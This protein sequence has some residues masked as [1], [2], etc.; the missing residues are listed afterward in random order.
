MLEGPPPPSAG[1]PT[2]TPRVTTLAA[3]EDAQGVVAPVVEHGLL[4]AWVVQDHLPRAALILLL[5]MVKV[6]VHGGGH[7]LLPCTISTSTQL[8]LTPPSCVVLVRFLACCRL[9]STAQRLVA[10][11]VSK[12][13]VYVQTCGC[14][15]VGGDGASVAHPPPSGLVDGGSVVGEGRF[16]EVLTRLQGQLY[17]LL[18]VR[19]LPIEEPE[20]G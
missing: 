15:C 20:E 12:T 3:L 5:L 16:H 8:L 17:Q 10:K 14:E 13:L 9:L 11:K 6:V 19:F 7:L 1:T 2:T 18:D 4:L